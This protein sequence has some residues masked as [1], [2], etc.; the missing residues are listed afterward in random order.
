M[1]GQT[2]ISNYNTVQK[3]QFFIERLVE[4]KNE[5]SLICFIGAGVSIS[6]G[7]P[8][9]NQY[10]EQLIDYWKGHL[11]VLTSKEETVKDNVEMSDMLFLESLQSMPASNKR[12]VDLVNFLLKEYCETG[13]SEKTLELYQEHVLDFERKIFTETQPILIKNDILDELVKLEPIF[14]TTNYD[15]QIEKSYERSTSKKSKKINSIEEIEGAVESN[16]V[17]HIHGVPDAGCNPDYFV[18]SARSYAGI[19]FL[20]DKQEKILEILDGKESPVFLFVGCSMEEDEI[21]ALLKKIKESRVGGLKAYAL[22]RLEDIHSI[23]VANDRKKKIIESYYL[24][25]H[26]VDILWFG[27][28]FEEL[29]KFIAKFVTKFKDKRKNSISDPERLRGVLTINDQ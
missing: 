6:Q 29:A 4:A 20:G 1:E 23:P 17:I 12:K 14:I 25:E 26:N 27:K 15:N 10:V 9:W 7:Y 18:S 2:I 11:D 13:E 3:E 28:E 24:D 21:L 22:M 16:T 5:N 8:N 19:Y